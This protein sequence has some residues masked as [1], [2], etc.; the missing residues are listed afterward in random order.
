MVYLENP[1]ES[2]T[3]KLPEISDFSKVTAYQATCKTQ[4]IS[5]S[6]H[7]HMETKIQ[8]HLQLCQE[9]NT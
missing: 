2:T 6:S 9:L 7:K 3:Y 1:K 4:G 8:C 5:I